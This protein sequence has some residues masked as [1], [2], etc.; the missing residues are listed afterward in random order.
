MTA[1]RLA[2]EGYEPREERLREALCT[3]GNGYMATRGAAPEHD[4]GEHHYPGTYVAGVFN[5]L[6]TEVAGHLVENESMVN[7]PSWLPLTFRIDGGEWFD[8][9]AAEVIEHSQVLDIRQALLVRRTTWRD[10]GGRTTTVTQRR[11]VHMALPHVCG[12]ETTI[13]A[14]DWSGHLEVRSGLDGTVANT[15]VDRYRDLASQHL[16]L[17]RAE[18]VDDETVLLVVETNQS[19]IRVAEAARHRARLVAGHG[20][21]STGSSTTAVVE[22]GAWIGHLLAV[23]V[24]AGD[25]LTVEKLVAVHTSRDH[26][27][28]EPAFSACRT[29]GALGT[30]DEL[31]ASHVLAWDHLWARFRTDIEGHDD[32]LR[33]VRLHTLHLLQTVSAA[34][35]G[36]DV[37]VPARGL[38]GEAYRGHI[39]WDELFVFPVLNLRMPW[40]TRSLLLYRYR[41]LDEARRAAREA[42]F[43]GAM[44][45]WQSGSDG[46]EENQTLHLN[47][48]SGRWLPDPTHRQRHIGIAIAYNVWQYYQ[49]TGD[50]EFLFHHGA[51]M[52]LEIAR[53]WSSITTYDR[54]RDRY[55][56][57][58]VIGPD[59]FH[60]GYPG[61][62]TEGIDNNAY[63]NVMAVW[64]LERAL[65][66]LE[67]LPPSRRTELTEALGLRPEER[68]RWEDISRKMFVPMHDGVVSQ[69][70]G[71]EDLEELDWVG[72]QERYGDIHRLD[73]ILE[74]EGDDVNRY[75]ASKQADVLMLLYLLSTDELAELFTRLGYDLPAETL[76]RTI[77]HYLA[78]T[79]HGS[80]LSAVVH[81]WVLARSHR[82]QALDFFFRVLESD[83]ADVQGGTTA[84]GIHL[85]A[86]TGS[87]DLL[88]RCFAGITMRGDVLWLDTHWPTS[89][90]PLEMAIRYREQRLVLRVTG[91]HVRVSSEEGPAAPIRV[92]CLGQVVELS[93]GESLELDT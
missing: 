81:S 55:V 59:E 12:L 24:D 85:A 32:A 14:H 38:H 2:Y 11:F 86:M 40:V 52:L 47:P 27:I 78:R 61:A 89:L 71:Y 45:P 13:T 6:S 26:A 58:G 54:A 62:E 77:D 16:E 36:L 41:R 63:T 70:E 50:R 15:G 35:V 34:S 44:F 22:D 80:T 76:P 43:E 30:F 83:V 56:I 10:A 21:I 57:R 75:K 79:S 60:T 82:G 92:G 49:A 64:V 33:I 8:L 23:D 37:G 9:D 67:L 7:V 25:Q 29:V 1:W 5:R 73:R 87:L 72:Y 17:V 18:P 68:D 69:F 93:P 19:R 65:E 42:G 51:E 28:S 90:G 66:T 84:E 3:L 53:F 48:A 46:R 4:A 74:A 31:V 91:E 39:F 88:A 20:S